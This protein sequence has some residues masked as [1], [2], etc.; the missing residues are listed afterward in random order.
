MSRKPQHWWRKANPAF[1]F[2]TSKTGAYTKAKGNVVFGVGFWK[3]GVEASAHGYELATRSINVPMPPFPDLTQ[4]E[5]YLL[6]DAF[7][8][9]EMTWPYRYW[10]DFIKAEAGYTQ[11]SIWKLDLPQN[12]LVEAFKCFIAEQRVIA[13]VKPAG[14]GRSSKAPSWALV[15]ILDGVNRSGAT[16]CARLLRRAKAKGR[17]SLKVISEAVKANHFSPASLPHLTRLLPK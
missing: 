13:N 15:E 8:R 11:P 9:S 3:D 12:A 4:E 6:R 7:N 10:P 1:S 5:K 2:S 17:A 16:D 14:R